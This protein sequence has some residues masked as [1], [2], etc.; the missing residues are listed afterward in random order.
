MCVPSQSSH[1]FYLFIMKY[2]LLL[3]LI[4]IKT[5][6]ILING[7][8]KARDYFILPYLILFEATTSALKRSFVKI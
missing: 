2:E 4:L 3:F 5:L 1:P 8:I 7:A 6:I